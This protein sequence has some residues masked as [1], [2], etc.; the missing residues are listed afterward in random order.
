MNE[1]R[2]GYVGVHVIEGGTEGGKE[3]TEGRKDERR[4]GRKKGVMAE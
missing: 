1:G 2:R 3:D 4:H